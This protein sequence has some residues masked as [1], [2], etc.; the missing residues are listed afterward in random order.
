[1]CNRVVLPDPFGPM[2]ATTPPA[3]TV[4]VPCDQVSR[5]PR[6]AL[7]PVNSSAGASKAYS[8]GGTERL[9][10][11][12]KLSV[13]PA[14]KRGLPRWDGLSHVDDGHPGLFGGRTDLR[15]DRALGLGVVDQDVDTSA[16][17]RC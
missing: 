16:S 6:T 4:K 15:R 17:Q 7:T 8:D 2:I 11:C 13:L 12:D 5:P 3:G 1:M 10:Q 14:L 9:P